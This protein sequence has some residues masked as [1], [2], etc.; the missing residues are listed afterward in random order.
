ML[1]R[2]VGII[3]GKAN[4]SSK[5][6]DELVEK[7]QQKLSEGYK[8]TGNYI[9]PKIYASQ[10]IFLEN[11]LAHIIN[12]IEDNLDNFSEEEL[13]KYILPHPLLG[14]LTYREMMYFTIYHAQHHEK[15]VR[16][17]FAKG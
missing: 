8:A 4:R 10:K 13:D 12:A 17:Y 16:G 7:Y 5:S 14:K 3:F 9:P 1:F 11:K 15:I 2:S 6:Y